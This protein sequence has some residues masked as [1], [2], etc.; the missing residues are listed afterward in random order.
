MEVELQGL[1]RETLWESLNKTGILPVPNILVSS[2]IIRKFRELCEIRVNEAPRSEALSDSSFLRMGQSGAEYW[3]TYPNQVD[4]LMR[5]FSTC[6]HA[7]SKEKK[8]IFL[9]EK[10]PLKLSS[11][12]LSSSSLVPRITVS[13][14]T[15]AE[16]IICGEEK[17]L[18]PWKYTKF[19][20]HKTGLLVN[21]IEIKVE[22][23]LPHKETISLCPVLV[24]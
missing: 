12:A 18:F 22:D 9:S 24:S 10:M 7:I 20:C 6:E 1:Q 23:I 13:V 19:I 11:I 2:I 21:G 3:A 5:N 14:Q 8:S 4:T 17:A 15:D 16:T